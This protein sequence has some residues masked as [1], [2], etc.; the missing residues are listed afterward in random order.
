MDEI[1]DYTRL[2]KVNTLC[3]YIADGITLKSDSYKRITINLPTTHKVESEH[4][5]MMITIRLNAVIDDVDDDY[6]NGYITSSI[7]DEKELQN[8]YEIKKFDGLVVPASYENPKHISV[9]YCKSY[10]LKGL[11]IAF[12]TLGGPFNSC[13]GEF[14]APLLLYDD[15]LS[16]VIKS[17]TDI[18]DELITE[19]GKFIKGKLWDIDIYPKIINLDDAVN[20][21]AFCWIID[22]EDI[23]RNYQ[24]NH[25]N[26]N[27]VKLIRSFGKNIFEKY[28]GEYIDEIRDKLLQVNPNDPI[29]TITEGQKMIPLS[30]IETSCPMDI[31]YTLW[32]EIA[33]GMRWVL[34]TLNLVTPGFIGAQRWEY[35][36]NTG[37]HSYDNAAMHAKFKNARIADDIYNLL[38][39]ANLKTYLDGTRD[40]DYINSKFAKVSRDIKNAMVR[41]SELIRLSGVSVLITSEFIG[42]TFGDLPKL[43]NSNIYGG[44]LRRDIQN[45]DMHISYAFM[46][47]HALFCMNERT[48]SFHSDLHINNITLNDI[49]HKKSGAQGNHIIVDSAHGTYLI[50]YSGV[51]PCIID[52]SR[53]ITYDEEWITKTDIYGSTNAFI[54]DQNNKL[55]HTFNNWYPTL[56]NK[57]EKE[58]RGLIE[59]SPALMIKILSTRDIIHSFTGIYQTFISADDYFD[60]TFLDEQKSK[61]LDITYDKNSH[62]ILPPQSAYMWKEIADYAKEIFSNAIKSALRGEIT[63]HNQLEWPSATILSHF[64]AKHKIT[65]STL[66]ALKKAIAN[67]TPGAE[68]CGYTLPNNTNK[69][70]ICD[71]YNYKN[72]YNIIP[73]MLSAEHR[74]IYNLPKVNMVEYIANDPEM[75][76]LAT[77]HEEVISFHK[78][79]TRVDIKN[80]KNR[81]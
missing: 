81:V 33:F 77:E 1:Y 12:T 48:K 15:R 14:R 22:Y 70:T 37:K 69:I 36:Y 64:F 27:Y 75:K 32:R 53:C 7:T 67:P 39:D 41:N 51:V 78:L 25:M 63:D 2:H 5:E 4:A 68:V 50:K 29:I 18:F 46:L 9:I 44:Q 73:D 71:Y 11:A 8:D 54:A 60:L 35:I 74:K 58:I 47:I 20:L 40:S 10:K 76:K 80:A 30:I 52:A 55:L 56:M 17:Y 38:K 26:K 34:M 31:R 28:G 79:Q 66:P 45:Y 62:P 61:V 3:R 72:D 43:C 24:P 42:R 59:K 13:D 49:G 21:L 65:K 57:H 16:D 19:I 6:D 23:S